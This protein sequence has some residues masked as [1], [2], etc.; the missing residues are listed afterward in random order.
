MRGRWMR[1][2][3]GG[4]LAGTNLRQDGKN[5]DQRLQQYQHPAQ[6]P[7]GQHYLAQHTSHTGEHVRLNNQQGSQDGQRLRQPCQRQ[8]AVEGTA[9]QLRG[10]NRVRVRS[11]MS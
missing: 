5:Q 3:I 8:E 4:V 11:G 6:V 9:Q 1:R 2:E 10:E 7:E